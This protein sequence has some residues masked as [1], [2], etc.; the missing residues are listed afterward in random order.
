MMGTREIYECYPC[1]KKKEEISTFIIITEKKK[2][3][4]DF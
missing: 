1:D 2:I 4:S 3:K